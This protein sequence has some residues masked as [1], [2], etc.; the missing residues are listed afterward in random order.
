MFGQWSLLNNNL[1]FLQVN[2]F[3]WVFHYESCLVLCFL[4]YAQPSLTLVISLCC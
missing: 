4:H 2:I 1:T 3:V